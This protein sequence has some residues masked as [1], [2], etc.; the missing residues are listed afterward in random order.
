MGGEYA[1]DPPMTAIRDDM[2]SFFIFWSMWSKR[3][4]ISLRKD[5]QQRLEEQRECQT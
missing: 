2:S 3:D 4:P 1:Q 5:D